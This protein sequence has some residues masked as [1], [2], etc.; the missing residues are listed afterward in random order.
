[1][2]VGEE[3]MEARCARYRAERDCARQDAARLRREVEGMRDRL[4][5]EDMEWLVEAWPRFEDDV[6][7][8]FLDDFERYGEENGVGA[9]TMYSD[10]S[11]ALNCRAYSKGEHVNRPAPK[12][13]DADGVEIR[14]G[15]VLYRIS[16]GHA[17]NVVKV[18]EKTFTDSDGYVRPC[19]G[20]THR[21]PVFAADGLPLREGEHVWHVE[22][23]TELVVK[24]LPKPGAYQA[25]VVFAPPASHL[26]SFDPDQLI[27]ERPDSWER[28]DDDAGKNPFDYCKHVGHRLDTCEDSE[29]YKARDLVRRARALAE[30]GK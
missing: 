27:H 14:A 8:R 28:L 13:P 23:G 6:P 29:A 3:S 11:F 17:V 24:E 18:G 30:R 12:V 15:D 25:V 9:V 10:G 16:D 26:T 5:P 22:T 20:F 21:A 2:G 7:V 4:M 1:M 19:D